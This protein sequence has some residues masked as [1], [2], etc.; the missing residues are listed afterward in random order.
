MEMVEEVVEGGGGEQQGRRQQHGS[1]LASWDQEVRGHPA[2][3][4]LLAGQGFF[5]V[6]SCMFWSQGASAK[7]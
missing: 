1:L 5:Q 2:L 7:T 3:G 4:Q 6:G